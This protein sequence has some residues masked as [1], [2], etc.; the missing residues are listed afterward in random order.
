MS[1]KNNDHRISYQGIT[2]FSFAFDCV[3]VGGPSSLTGVFYNV[4]IYNQTNQTECI[5]L[6]KESSKLGC[7]NVHEYMTLP[8]LVG[9]INVDNMLLNAN[10]YHTMFAMADSIMSSKGCYQ[11]FNEAICKIVFPICDPEQKV[12]VPPCQEMC[13]ELGEICI[14]YLVTILKL[15]NVPYDMH[16]YRL[17]RASFPF[18]CNYLPSYTD[19]TVPCFYK[20][21]ICPDPLNVT[22]AVMLN[23][24]DNGAPYL[25]NSTVEYSC[26]DNT[27]K[28]EGNSISTCQYS[29]EWSEPPSCIQSH[30]WQQSPTTYCIA[31]VYHT[32]DDGFYSFTL[33]LAEKKSNHIYALQK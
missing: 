29:G 2:P 25:G 31:S 11:H 26:K 28:M 8:N 18:N 33:L 1:W 13:F 16:A 12:M 20:P 6:P 27:F 5:P 21:V 22:N 4:S 23:Q 30:K 24:S 17:K 7:R 10:M 19:K 9:K 3:D 32:T 14:K 15:K